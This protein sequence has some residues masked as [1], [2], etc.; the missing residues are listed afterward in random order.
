MHF[1]IFRFIVIF[2][3]YVLCLKERCSVRIR[4][5]ISGFI[6]FFGCVFLNVKSLMERGVLVILIVLCWVWCWRVDKFLF[7]IF[8]FFVGMVLLLFFYWVCFCFCGVV[9]VLVTCLNL[10]NFKVFVSFIVWLF[11]GC[12][13]GFLGYPDKC[14]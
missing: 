5:I 13:F 11:W 1:I 2:I 7:R 9:V 14:S 12:R 6:L 4:F 3:F 8:G 10:L